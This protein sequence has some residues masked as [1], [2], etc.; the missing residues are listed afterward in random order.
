MGSVFEAERCKDSVNSDSSNTKCETSSVEISTSR[1]KWNTP[2]T[3]I[4]HGPTGPEST[5][6]SSLHCEAISK[7]SGNGAD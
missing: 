1:S 3:T 2:R 5:R 7:F 4:L 6:G